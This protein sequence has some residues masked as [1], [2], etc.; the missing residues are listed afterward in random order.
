MPLTGIRA[1]RE[2]AERLFAELKRRPSHAYLFTGPR[3]VGKATVATALAHGLLC[4]RS[5][6]AGFCCAV[7]RCAVRTAPPPAPSG[8]RRAGDDAPRCDCC[9]ACVQIASGVHP[10]FTRI[11][12]AANR[13]DVL[14]EQVRGLIAA[15]GI[16]PSRSNMRVAIIDDAETLNI[17][18]QNALLKTLEE[19][20]GHAII[21]MITSS[22][23]ALLDTVRS[24]L[25][26]V[27]FGALPAADL[28][29][30]L[31]DHGVTDA[32]RRT[33]A[34]R[35][36]RGSAA[37]ALTLAAGEE[38]A[39]NELLDALAR[40]RTF[41]F[42]SA[43]Q[44]AEAHFRTRDEATENFELIARLLEEILC[45]KLLGSENA[46]KGIADLAAALPLEAIVA[47]IEGAVRAR[48]AVDAMANPRLQAEQYWMVA[49]Q[50]IRG[51]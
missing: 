34:S 35:L 42:A 3:G 50:A 41:D 8:R 30:I 9:A 47:C 33:A 26:P 40:A 38:P 15:L 23:Q 45:C 27:R 7:E 49:A 19:P 28:E 22:D 39:M 20:P 11:G 29:A 46:V 31:A 48:G 36:A 13:T 25:R 2:L 32:T 1:H 14:I 12:R 44:I 17:P 37:R 4:E 43:Q 21:F 6:G 18:A 10:D 24:R 16:K 51:E 5:S